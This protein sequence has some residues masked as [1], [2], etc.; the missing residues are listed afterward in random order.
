MSFI[1]SVAPEYVVISC[2]KDNSYG[3]PHQETLNLLKSKSINVFRTDEQGNIVCTSDGKT[4]S[5]SAEP[6]TTWKAG[7]NRYDANSSQNSDNAS[8]SEQNNT[9]AALDNN[10]EQVTQTAPGSSYVINTNT[11]KFHIPSCESVKQ[12][13]EKNRKDV[14]TTRDEV[15]SMG[16]DPC[17]NCN[18]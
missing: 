5:W 10:I 7:S 6:S 4:L 2:G 12:M 1:N 3:H 8:L 15:I 14:T 13:K 17:K 9:I 18:P 11:G 16:Y